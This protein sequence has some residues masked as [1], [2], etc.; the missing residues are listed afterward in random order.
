M[1]APVSE[2]IA[3]PNPGTGALPFEKWAT[4]A[5][6]GAQPRPRH[7]RHERQDLV[8]D[9]MCLD[10][11]PFDPSSIANARL[12]CKQMLSKDCGDRQQDIACPLDRVPELHLD[13]GETSRLISALDIDRNNSC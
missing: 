2:S 12:H 11:S 6:T 7:A 3:D 8:L 10:S 5:D 1:S 9:V 4:V 13:C